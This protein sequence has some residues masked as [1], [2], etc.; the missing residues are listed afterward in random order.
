MKNVK[1]GAEKVDSL[2]SGLQRGTRLAG[3]GIDAWNNVAKIGRGLGYDWPMFDG[4]VRR[5]PERNIA[6]NKS[7]S[8][9]ESIITN[10]ERYT[11]KDIANAKNA[12]QNLSQ[13]QNQV[14]SERLKNLTVE[15]AFQHPEYYTKK[16]LDN[17][18]ARSNS[19]DN[20]W[21]ATAR[22]QEEA[23]SYA[24]MKAEVFNKAGEDKKWFSNEV[25][26]WW[27]DDKLKL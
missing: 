23:E 13:A 18:I 4:N 15:Q 2:I 8:Q 11:A 21:K 17:A 7:L 10:P 5:A 20:I 24:N 19:L 12:Y 26:E 14:R 6:N 16:E 25:K 9:L 3:A 27:D 1:T 22:K